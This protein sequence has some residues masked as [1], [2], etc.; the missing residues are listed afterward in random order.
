MSKKSIALHVFAAVL[1]LVYFLVTRM[2]VSLVVEQA[3]KN[4]PFLSIGEASGSLWNGNLSHLSI[5][6]QSRM[7]DLG[8][9][10][11]K[12]RPAHLLLGDLALH[13]HAEN[14]VQVIDADI[15]LGIGKTL[16][17]KNGEFLFEAATLTRIYPIP[18]RI[19]GVIELN[20]DNLKVVSN[21]VVALEANGVMKNLAYTMNAPVELGTYGGRFTMEKEKIKADLSDVDARVGLTGFASFDVIKKGYEMDVTLSPKN[22]ANPVI[23]QSLSAFVAPEPDGTFHISKTGQL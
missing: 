15:Q 10:Q 9:T 6:Y 14:G 23:A 16:S 17:I 18:G 13:I 22:T 2:P 4:A 3:R 1:I 21:T 12:I 7:I 5:N 19:D 8:R 11:W 20:V